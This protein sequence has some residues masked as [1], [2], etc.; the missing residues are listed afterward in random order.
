MLYSRQS[1]GGVRQ[2][3]ERLR[4]AAERKRF[5]VLA[6]IDLKA[7][8][9]EKGVAFDRDCVIV[10]L[11]NP[12]QAAQV[13][14]HDPAIATSLPCRIAVWA[15]GSGG[16]TAATVRPAALLKMYAAAEPLP[17]VADEV[18]NAL[19]AIIDEACAA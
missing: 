3:V 14:R 15:D 2:L 1:A 13:L 4:R 5:G 19:V 6:V 17:G 16:V 18:E 11:C 9:A 12:R 10:E 7:K 8:I